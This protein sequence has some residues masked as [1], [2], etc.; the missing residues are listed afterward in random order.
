MMSR[1]KQLLVYGGIIG[2]VATALALGVTAYA[3]DKPLSQMVLSAQKTSD[4]MLA[5]LFAALGQE[6][7]ETPT[8]NVQQGKK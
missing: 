2:G 5:T 1:T 4:L 3:D 6:F 8:E 7:A